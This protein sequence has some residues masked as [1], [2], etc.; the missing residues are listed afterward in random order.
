MIGLHLHEIG[1]KQVILGQEIGAIIP[2][3]GG[4]AAQLFDFGQGH[5]MAH[6]RVEIQMHALVIQIGRA[7]RFAMRVAEMIAFLKPL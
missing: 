5:G 6:M 1:G 2:G 3:F 7:R 4:R